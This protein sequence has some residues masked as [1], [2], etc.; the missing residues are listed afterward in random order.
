MDKKAYVISKKYTDETADQFGGL[1]GANA[2]IKSIVH[3]DGQNVVTFLWRNDAGEERESQMTVVDG[4]DGT[5]IYP[6]TPGTTYHVGDLVIY[7]NQW[8]QCIS[9]HVATSTFNPAKFESIGAV[10]GSYAIV[11]SSSALPPSFAS[12]DRKMYY[13]IADSAFWLWT[14][15][16]WEIQTQSI[17]SAEIDELFE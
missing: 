8:Y 2:Q 4:V 16:Q 1:K 12:T 17:S 13:S 15:T 7:D 10:D 6:Y 11:E 14:G 5:P 3:E 9:E